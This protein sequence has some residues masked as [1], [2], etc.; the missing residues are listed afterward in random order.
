MFGAYEY[1]TIDKAAI[2][3]LPANNP[4]A[5]QQNGNYPFNSTEHLVDARVDHRFNDAQSTFV[6]Y[7]FDDQFTPSGGPDNAASSIVDNSKS[8]SIV[9]EHNWVLAPEHG[10]HASLPLPRPQPVHGADQ[11]RPA[12]RPSL[13]YV[14]TERRGAAVLPPQDRQLLRDLLHP[15][16]EPR[17]QARRRVHAR[18]EQLR[19]ALHRAR[20]VHVPRPTRRSMPPIRGPGRSP[21]SSRRPGSTTTRRIRSP[22]SSRTTGASPTACA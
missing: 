20:R 18:L 22:P 6:R 19:S 16:A 21:S 5:T 7:A 9:G 14:R 8:H 13:V 10:Q 17:H 2:V 3:S 12:D 11:L 4:F 1:L 15:H